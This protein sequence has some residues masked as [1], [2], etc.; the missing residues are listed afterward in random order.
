[1]KHLCIL[2]INTRSKSL[3]WGK[4]RVVGKCATS[5]IALDMLQDAIL[6]FELGRPRPHFACIVC[7]ILKSAI[8]ACLCVCSHLLCRRSYFRAMIICVFGVT[9]E[10]TQEDTNLSGNVR[11]RNLSYVEGLVRWPGFS[12]GEFSRAFSY[13]A[14]LVRCDRTSRS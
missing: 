2:Q 7:S 13:T 6:S 4:H 5:D 11:L 14:Q 3:V 8:F 12:L 10:V 1:M 9:A